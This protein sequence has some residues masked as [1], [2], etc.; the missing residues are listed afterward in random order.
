MGCILGSK[1][2]RLCFHIFRMSIGLLVG[3]LV[4]YSFGL[5][6]SSI[7]SNI[8]DISMRLFLGG[9]VAGFRRSLNIGLGLLLLIFHI[10]HIC[11]SF[12]K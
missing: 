6:R 5:F 3:V 7:F 11:L 1:L 9:N 2:G 8:A 10:R 12:S 4:Q